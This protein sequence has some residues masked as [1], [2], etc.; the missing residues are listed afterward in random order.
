M[1]FHS[2]TVYLVAANSSFAAVH[3]LQLDPK[4]LLS[5]WR[6]SLS[7]SAR[8]ASIERSIESAYEVSIEDIRSGILSKDLTQEFFR[9]EG[10]QLVDRSKGI[11]VIVVPYV[12]SPRRIHGT[13][14]N[15]SSARR[16]APLAISAT[17]SRSGALVRD[18]DARAP[19][20]IRDYL[21]PNAL[22]FAFGLL[23][24]CDSFYSSHPFQEST[25]EETMLYAEELFLAVTGEEPENFKLP[26]CE[27]EF[28]GRIFESTDSVEAR[29]LLRLYNWL[30]T[31]DETRA[32][33]ALRNGVEK[34]QLLTKSQEW[35][36][37]DLHKGHPN[38]KFPLAESQRRM[39]H[40]FLSAGSEDPIV[41][42]NGPPGTG[43]TTLIQSI[44]A[45]LW[46]NAALDRS[47]CPLIVATSTSNQA[48]TNV[49]KAFDTIDLNI[50]APLG[51]RW[52]SLVSSYGMY[53]AS[54][55]A[56]AKLKAT[57]SLLQTYSQLPT[58][59]NPAEHFAS[60]YETVPGLAEGIEEFLASANRSGLP[61]TPFSSV[62]EAQSSIHSEMVP[63]D[64]G[65]SQVVELLGHLSKDS[66]EFPS[67]AAFKIVAHRYQ[68]KIEA[69]AGALDASVS[70]Y[71][72]WSSLRDRWKKHR[73]VEPWSVWVSQLFSSG[74]SARL[75]RDYAFIRE[76][77]LWEMFEHA[78]P[79]SFRKEVESYISDTLTELEGAISSRQD[80][81]D[82]VNLQSSAFLEKLAEF[83]EWCS[84]HSI[85]GDEIGITTVLDTE[86][87]VYA[88]STCYSLLG[89]RISSGS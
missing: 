36:V 88:L 18:L 89:G 26:I 46:V 59:E 41:V 15:T 52:L 57:G 86:Y 27:L 75:S 16:I 45:S 20:F 64:T 17:L 76:S 19:V 56:K 83:S 25:W 21:E 47:E 49:N 82:S 48:V 78:E 61:G 23:E 30:A 39:V 60:Y 13:S 11:S 53:L 80:E 66:G 71:S 3:R 74:R 1:S 65:L 37:S 72:G 87:A 62:A 9:R 24:T 29:H 12:Y 79:A 84:R 68:A 10:T 22:P 35:V 73:K 31:Q 32:V 69:A 77:G 40:H 4:A 14:S 54:E 44:V 6:N 58:R 8:V 70:E 34:R 51:G 85:D 63:R 38:R 50:E 67:L 33:T 81:L 42:V 28:S 2:V 7:D 55:T 5:Y 43:K